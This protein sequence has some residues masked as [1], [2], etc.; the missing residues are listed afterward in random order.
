MRLIDVDSYEIHEVV[1]D[2]IPAYAILSHCWGEAEVS[3]SDI[4]NGEAKGKL[5]FQKIYY[6]CEQAKR[7]FL[8]W[9][10][11][12]TCCIDKTSSAEL[13]EAINSMYQ[14]YGEAIACYVY[15]SDITFGSHAPLGASRWF[16]RGWTLQELV[17]P[18]EVQFFNKHWKW[19]GLRDEMSELLEGV[20]GIPGA[21][22]SGRETPL[23]H[24][25][26]ARMSWA[27]NRSCTRVEDIAYCLLG[28]FDVNLPLIYEEGKKAF[29][30]LQE[31]ILRQTVDQTLLAWTV[32]S[33]SPQAWTRVGVLAESPANFA[34]CGGPFEISQG[35][36]EA[37]EYDTTG[38][39]DIWSPSSP[40]TAR[41]HR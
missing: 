27:S 40:P 38:F 18:E 37:L 35:E 13:S 17:A 29:I 32:D 8:K 23:K 15:L 7:D 3:L 1:A 2:Q 31:E 28:L 10:W 11:V 6:A 5:G 22:L 12:D 9:V 26:A 41:Q 25:V 4:Q 30:R 16:T 20:T 39:G 36:L 19:I 14:W 34:S 24:T 33:N 21:V